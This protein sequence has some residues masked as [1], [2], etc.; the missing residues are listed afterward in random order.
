MGRLE[1]LIP[2]MGKT[3]FIGDTEYKVCFINNE[4]CRFSADPNSEAKSIPQMGNK[5][6]IESNSYKV[7]YVHETKK[8]ITA[9]PL[10]VGY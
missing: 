9:I 5:F 8:R 2:E 10:S 6:M 3:F 1:E 7:T 4:K